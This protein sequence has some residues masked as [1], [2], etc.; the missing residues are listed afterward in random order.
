MGPMHALFP[1]ALGS[2]TKT[3]G[4]PGPQWMAI[5]Y[6]YSGGG[7]GGA[8]GVSRPG[9]SSGED[10]RPNTSGQRAQVMVQRSQHMRGQS[11]CCMYMPH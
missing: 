7:G 8:G 2:Q 4:P 9:P 10:F 6:L 11:C 3:V 5:Y 1:F